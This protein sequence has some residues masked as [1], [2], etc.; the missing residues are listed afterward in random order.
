MFIRYASEK[1][2]KKEIHEWS[3]ISLLYNLKLLPEIAYH[4]F[5]HHKQN[6]ISF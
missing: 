2:N 5:G 6:P 4:P 1:S 3:Q